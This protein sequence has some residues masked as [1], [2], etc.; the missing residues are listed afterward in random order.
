MRETGVKR[1]RMEK[2]RGTKENQRVLVGGLTQKGDVVR[3]WREE[4]ERER[5]K[6]GQRKRV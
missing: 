4:R 3:P 1:Y 5:E 6:E 2:E